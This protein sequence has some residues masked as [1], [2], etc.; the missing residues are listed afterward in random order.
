LPIIFSKDLI[1]WKQVWNSNCYKE[2]YYET[3]TYLIYKNLC[4]RSDL[5]FLK[6]LGQNGATLTS[7]LLKFTELME[8]FMFTFR[9]ENEVVKQHISQKENLMVILLS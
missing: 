5:Y 2:L 1:N 9:C 8:L 3:N 4:S 7:G 6:I